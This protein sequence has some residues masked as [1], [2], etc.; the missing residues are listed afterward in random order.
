MEN[1]NCWTVLFIRQEKGEVYGYWAQVY[2]SILKVKK[3]LNLRKYC[4]NI[5]NNYLIGHSM[6][7][8]ILNGHSNWFIVLILTLIKWTNYM[9]STFIEIVFNYLFFFNF[10]YFTIAYMYTIHCCNVHYLF[11]TP[12]FQGYLQN[13][14]LTLSGP[15][16]ESF[17]LLFNL[18]EYN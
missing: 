18:T 1:T 16:K 9:L 10:S 6:Q 17:L 2:S 3:V 14:S 5:F 11:T 7:C 8:R 4:F 12:I 13:F 15:L